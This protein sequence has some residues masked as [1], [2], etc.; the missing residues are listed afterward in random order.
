MSPWKFGRTCLAVFAILLLVCR[1]A[2]AEPSDSAKKIRI[3]LYADEGAATEGWPQVKKALPADKGFEI[4]T[5]TAE[6]IRGGALDRFDVL[7]QPGGSASAQSAKLGEEGCKHVKAFVDQGGGYIGICAGAYLASAEYPWSLHLLDAHVLDRAH[8]DRGK[9]H[10]QLKFTSA[11]KAALAAASESCDIHFENGPLLGP[12]ENDDINDY[13]PL[14][15]YETEITQN[16][17][18]GLMKGTTAIARGTFGKGRVLCFSPHPEKTPGR[19]PFLQSA[20]RWV[21]KVE[22]VPK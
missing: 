17:P 10:V 18:A 7:I 11:G 12:G 4:A 16:A 21:A 8:W 20:V 19:E 14:A 1:S 3:A 6:E 5:V 15:E 13:E 22:D 2:T 9:G